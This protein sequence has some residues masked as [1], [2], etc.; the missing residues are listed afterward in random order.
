[1]PALAIRTRLVTGGATNK[2]WTPLMA[3]ATHR[4]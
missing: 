4:L 1:M 2:P 3:P